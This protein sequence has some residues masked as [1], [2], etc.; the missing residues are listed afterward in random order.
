MTLLPEL[1]SDVPST[2]LVLGLVLGQVPAWSEVPGTGYRRWKL[3]RRVQFGPRALRPWT[4]ELVG[5]AVTA[6]FT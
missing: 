3:P 5:D 6:A 4:Y 1:S 2:G